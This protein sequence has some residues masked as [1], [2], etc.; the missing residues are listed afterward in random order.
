M[1]KGR[2]PINLSQLELSI[3][4]V[5]VEKERYGL[6]IIEAVNSATEG[7]RTL[8]LGSLYTTLHRLEK[9]G[10]ITSR[11]GETVEPRQGARRRYYQL[12]AP[13]LEVLHETQLV[14]LRLLRLAPGADPA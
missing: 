6:E 12:T 10:L 7:K 2:L 14:L 5:L 4:S 3:L 11:W 9:K 8:S 1:A 13:G